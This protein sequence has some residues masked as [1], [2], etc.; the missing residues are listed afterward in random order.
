M[1]LIGAMVYEGSVVVASDSMVYDQGLGW[2]GETETKLWPIP[3]NSLIWGYAG[4]ASLG[5]WIGQFLAASNVL[6]TWDA[7]RQ[8]VA[9]AMARV[10]SD[11]RSYWQVA[12]Q[13]E[14]A[15][16]LPDVLVAGCI[17]G[18]PRIMIVDSR[19]GTEFIT[20][21]PAFIGNPLACGK[22]GIVIKAFKQERSTLVYGADLLVDVM[23]LVIADTLALGGKPQVWRVTK[24]GTELLQAPSAVG[25][26][27]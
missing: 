7:A 22:A 19:L 5:T 13:P 21:G 25:N 14:Q 3:N 1:T 8:A 4:Y 9:M 6:E 17:G 24:D 10:F 15:N 20:E 26:Q 27:L 16:V 18:E 12:R 23:A 11:Q 2:K